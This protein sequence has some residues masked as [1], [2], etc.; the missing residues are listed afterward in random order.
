MYRIPRARVVVARFELPAEPRHR[1]RLIEEMVW[2]TGALWTSSCS[3]GF[4]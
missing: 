4:S 3:S 2:D 1:A